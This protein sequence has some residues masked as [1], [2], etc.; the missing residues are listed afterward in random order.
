M[1]SREYPWLD[2]GC[3]STSRIQLLPC[4]RLYLYPLVLGTNIIPPSGYQLSIP[5]DEII[6]LEK[7]MTAFVIPNAI[8]ITT[9]QSKYTFASFL[10]RDTTYDVI[11]NIWRLVRPGT[12]SD[13]AS[14]GSGSRE[15]GII[16]GTIIGGNVDGSGNSPGAMVPGGGITQNKV[17]FCKCGKEGKH[18][19][20]LAMDTVIPGTPDKIHNLMFTSGFLKDFLV[21]N[22]K[23]IGE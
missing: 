21:T 22:Q 3:E 16:E 7:K 23:L 9:R 18:F 15:G 1:F 13:N 5:I 14:I 6:S 17:T 12:L 8:L 4:S 2:Y 19:S 20:E 10:S 11:Y